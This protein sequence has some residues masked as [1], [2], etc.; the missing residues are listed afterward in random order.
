MNN[1][2]QS[3]RIFAIAIIA[4]V[5]LFAG[6][7]LFL[8]KIGH[9]PMAPGLDPVIS[10]VGIIIAAA[11]I[12]ISFLVFKRRSEAAVNAR[13]SEKINFFRSAVIIQFAL[14]DAPAIFNVVAYLLGGNNQSLIIVACCIIVMLVQ[15]PTEE[16]YNRFGE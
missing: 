15:F 1:Q 13:E 14:L 7:A 4:G 12:A 16:K 9:V 2:L 6:I 8:D 10:Y 11:C 5:I 3:I